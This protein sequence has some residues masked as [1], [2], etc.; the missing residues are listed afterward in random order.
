MPRK[1]KA[2]VGKSSGNKPQSNQQQQQKQESHSQQAQAKSD[3]QL[4]DCSDKSIE[5]NPALLHLFRMGIVNGKNS[6]EKIVTNRTD[7]SDDEC[8][9]DEDEENR[10]NFDNKMKMFAKGAFRIDTEHEKFTGFLKT[11]KEMKMSEIAQNQ[12]CLKEAMSDLCDSASKKSEDSK[13]KKSRVEVVSERASSPPPLSS[14]DDDGEE[15]NLN[16]AFVTEIAQRKSKTSAI[17][18]KSQTPFL[19]AHY[20][21]E[22]VDSSD[23][24][25]QD[26]FSS[27]NDYHHSF[28]RFFETQQK[29]NS[30]ADSKA[31]IRERN[32]DAKD[33]VQKSLSFGE[34][35]YNEAKNGNYKAAVDL[36][37]TAIEFNPKNYIFY[38]N[39]SMCYDCLFD[40]ESALKDAEIAISLNPIWPK[41]Y[42][43]KGRA[44]MGL[45]RFEEAEV[46]FKKVLELEKHECEEAKSELLRCREEAVRQ[47][48]Y[49]KQVAMIAAERCR[50]VKAAVYAVVNCLVFST[51]PNGDPLLDDIDSEEDLTLN[52]NSNYPRED[53]NQLFDVTNPFGWKALWVGNLSQNADQTYLRE[54]FCKFGVLSHCGLYKRSEG[55]YALV[56]YDNP[57]SPRRAV[58]AYQGAVIKGISLNDKEKLILR[59]RPN[60]DQ[61]KDKYKER[62]EIGECYYWRTTGCERE[63]C[64]F[65]HIPANKGVDIQPWMI[66]PDGKPR[67][68]SKLQQQILKK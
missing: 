23:S 24:D 15:L 48:G 55:A 54:L 38:T 60:R 6:C 28:S 21:I 59:F 2:N 31:K 40:Y 3:V 33:R 20:T 67:N 53:I 5:I 51:K 27:N 1:K 14:S 44:L 25:S 46:A 16:S 41:C 50:S 36:F 63:S 11:M 42:Y 30:A 19:E 32:I 47:L 61:K 8:R 43:R 64:H 52:A 18:N 26:S 4:D 22:Y 45:K 13:N 17:S 10:E 9:F 34:Q 58:A 7:C 39:R 57:E 29:N 65:Q 56:H 37:K 68:R 12:R 66:T 35:A 49:D 62:L